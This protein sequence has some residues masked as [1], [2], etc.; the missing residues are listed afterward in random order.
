MATTVDV[1]QNQV[2]QIE[3][4]ARGAFA[5][6]AIETQLNDGVFRHFRCAKPGTG[7]YAFNITTFPGRLVVTGDIGTLV[8]E[9][10]RDMFEWAPNAVESIDYFAQ[11]VPSCMPTREWDDAIAQ[12]WLDEEISEATGDRLESLEMIAVSLEDGRQFFE[13]ALFES[14]LVDGCEWP[15]FKTYTADYLWC[16]E[17]V[18]WFFRNYTP[19]D[20]KGATR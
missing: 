8:V 2:A 4:F 5:E 7:S 9:R 10:V 15:D 16:R 12:A 6:H 18:R 13:I 17:A 19:P 11:K 3:A 1:R 20:T 14:G